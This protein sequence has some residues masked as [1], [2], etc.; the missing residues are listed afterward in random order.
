LRAGQA[1]DPA[2]GVRVLA[3]PGDAVARGQALAEL[4][5][6]DGAGLD[7]GRALAAS[8]FAIGDEAPDPA[9][10]ILGHVGAGAAAS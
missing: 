1:I 10:L 2:V 8:A 9:P 3:R 6:R 7:A 4:H 5:H